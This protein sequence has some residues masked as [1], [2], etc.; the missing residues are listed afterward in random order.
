[1]NHAEFRFSEVA[2]L[3]GDGRFEESN[4]YRD[5]SSLFRAYVQDIPSEAFPTFLETLHF[6]PVMACSRMP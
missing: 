4:F 3:L 5:L 1:M 6:E 2:E